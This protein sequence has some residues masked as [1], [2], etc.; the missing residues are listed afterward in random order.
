M[1]L[2]KTEPDYSHLPEYAEGTM[3]CS[4]CGRPTDNPPQRIANEKIWVCD[5]WACQDA[6]DHQEQR[7]RE[8]EDKYDEWRTRGE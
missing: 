6:F 8:A 2:F 4:Y 7:N 5:R 1:S 3:F